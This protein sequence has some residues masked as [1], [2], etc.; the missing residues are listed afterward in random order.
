MR[1]VL[2]G[3]PDAAERLHAVLRGLEVPS[4]ASDAAAAAAK[5]SVS[6]SPTARAASHVAARASS[7]R[8]SMLAQRCFT[9]WN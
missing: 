8:P 7:V 1:V 3:E 2:P 9:P 6:A 5:P 4:I